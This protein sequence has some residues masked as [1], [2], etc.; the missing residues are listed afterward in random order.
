MWQKEG[1]NGRTAQCQ[2]HMK[3][4]ALISGFADGKGGGQILWSLNKFDGA[5]VYGAPL[6]E[7]TK[8]M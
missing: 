5:P 2:G 7:L 4:A 3:P 1:G 6:K 8:L